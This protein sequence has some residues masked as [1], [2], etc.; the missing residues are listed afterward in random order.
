[1][2][3]FK[4]LIRMRGLCHQEIGR[5]ITS[6]KSQSRAQDEQ[7]FE[8]MKKRLDKNT[9]QALFNFAKTIDAEPETYLHSFRG[10][11]R[12]SSRGKSKFFSPQYSAN[13]H[14]LAAV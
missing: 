1:M 14:S 2:N 5:M 3:N 13:R 6:T 10:T 8:S 9:G 11:F 12:G 4:N 7:M